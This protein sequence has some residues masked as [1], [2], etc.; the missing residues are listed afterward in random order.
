[1]AAFSLRKIAALAGERQKQR[2]EVEFDGL[3]DEQ[4]SPLTLTPDG[5]DWAACVLR[6]A[7]IAPPYRFGMLEKAGLTPRL[8]QQLRDAMQ[9]HG[10]TE[11]DVVDALLQSVIASLGDRSDATKALVGVWKPKRSIFASRRTR[12]L[13]ADMRELV[14]AHTD[15]GREM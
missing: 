5:V 9:K 12:E 15:F 4:A 7:T 1:M 10:V 2:K 8:L 14:A 6:L 11:A 13:R 3:L